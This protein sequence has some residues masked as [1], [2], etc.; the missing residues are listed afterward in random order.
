MTKLTTLLI[1]SFLTIFTITWIYFQDRQPSVDP[2]LLATNVVTSP[3]GS[4]VTSL[5]PFDFV[6]IHTNTNDWQLYTDQADQFSFKYPPDWRVETIHNPDFPE[7]KEILSAHPASTTL[8][9]EAPL[10]VGITCCVPPKSITNF[11]ALLRSASNKETVDVHAQLLEINGNK[12]LIQN[13]ATSTDGDL[14]Y[15]YLAAL[16]KVFSFNINQPDG[17]IPHAL[18]I[19]AGI[20]NTFTVRK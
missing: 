9:G 12:I 19:S 15:I 3:T 17:Y 6:S 7:Y 10:E 5:N 13:T 14:V 16:Q 18:E 1:V 20:I 4:S 11:E 2:R 8:G